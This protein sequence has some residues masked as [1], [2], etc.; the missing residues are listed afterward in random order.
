VIS[1]DELRTIVTRYS[2]TAGFDVEELNARPSWTVR[3][4]A[5]A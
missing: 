3:H 5:T 4:P 2:R 1:R